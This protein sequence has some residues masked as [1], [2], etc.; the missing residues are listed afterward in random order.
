MPEAVW[1]IAGLVAGAALG[2][3]AAWWRTRTAGQ[4]AAAAEATGIELRKQVE[5]AAADFK[6]LDERVLAEGQARVRAETQRDET[7]RTI[8]EQKK[9]LA[10]AEERLREAFKAIS[11][12]AMKELVPQAK[13]TLAETVKPLDEAVKRYEERL[14]A[15]EK[16]RGEQYGSLDAQVKALVETEKALKKET[17]NLVT[18]LRRPEVRGRWGESTLRRLVELA[19]MSAHCD[20]TE[21]ASLTTGDGR[22]RPDLTIHL[23]GERRVL[24]DAKVALDAYLDAAGA[25]DAETREAAL[26]RHMR[27]MRDHAMK[28]ATKSYWEKYDDAAEFVVMFIPGEAFLAA[29]AGRDRA[30]IEDA[31]A[32]RVVPA[33]PT[34][35]IALLWS[36]AH[37]W[38]EERI[39][40]EAQAIGAA[41]R[42]LYD[43]VDVLAR[44]LADLG[45]HLGGA[46]DSHDK[47]VGSME[48][49]FLPAARRLKEL[50]ATAAEDIPGLA[51]IGRAPRAPQAPELA[52]GED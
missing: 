44:H 19:G 49:M 12:D 50:H 51:A 2:V 37:G 46:V 33:T 42:E 31:I 3:L 36:A 22:I 38:R 43:R 5:K 21:Q 13:G 23:P 29:A 41:G 52:E 28:L 10:A 34:T 40:E 26:D 47:F 1:F 17:A 16:T 45:R 20:F 30:L 4:R 6:A 7:L 39:A 25:G 8:D 11:A 24:V 35:L 18:A 32:K 14:G 48:R 9:F 27:Q 15:F